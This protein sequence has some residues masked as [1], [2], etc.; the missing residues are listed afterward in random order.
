MC[1]AN[2]SGY[3][4]GVISCE[5]CKV[6]IDLTFLHNGDRTWVMNKMPESNND[7]GTALFH[8]KSRLRNHNQYSVADPGFPRGVYQPQRECSL[9]IW[10][11][12]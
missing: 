6:R 7:T 1:G 11:N 10:H 2:S 9:I 4:F 12:F 5:A 8:V 3:H